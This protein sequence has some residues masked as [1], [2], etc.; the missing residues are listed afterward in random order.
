VDDPTRPKPDIS[1][2]KAVLGWEP[3]VPLSEGLTRVI[4]H[5]REKQAQEHK[6]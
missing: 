4:Q 6:Q 3:Q 1:K 2:A 5:F